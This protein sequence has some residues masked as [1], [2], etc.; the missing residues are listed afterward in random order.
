MCEY[1]PFPCPRQLFLQ[2]VRINHLRFRD[3]RSSVASIVNAIQS[4]IET[5]SPQDWACSK[6]DDHEDFRLLL[7]T[8]YQS[9][10]FLYASRALSYKWVS[11]SP[12]AS[13][14]EHHRGRLLALLDAAVSSTLYIYYI[15]W[16][17]VVAG[18]AFGKELDPGRGIVRNSLVSLVSRSRPDPCWPAQVRLMTAS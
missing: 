1:P 7:G 15:I 17:A 16:Q 18:A 6:K 11:C 12:F 10:V 5:F 8:I 3:Q 4:E 13:T 2:I 14:I 9:A